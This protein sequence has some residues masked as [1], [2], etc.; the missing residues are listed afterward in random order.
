M[1]TSGSV[2]VSVTSWNTLKFTW[3][4]E[5]QSAA[6]NASVVAWKMELVAGS[7]GYISST[8]SKDWSVTVNGTKYTGTNTVGISNNSTKTLASGRTTI[9]HNADGSKTFS[10]SF[11][12]EFAITFQG[13]NIGTKSGSGSGTL[14]VMEIWV[15]P[16]SGK[17]SKPCLR[18]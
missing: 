6:N 11:S 15:P 17:Y 1:A 4:L 8:A 18:E 14:T 7:D 12:Q 9:V 10:F 13:S 5:S 3:T 16:L 2:S